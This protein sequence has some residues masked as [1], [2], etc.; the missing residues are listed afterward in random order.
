M[1][2]FHDKIDLNTKYQVGWLYIA[3]V[4]INIIFNASK[5]LYNICFTIIPNIYNNFN[6]KIKE[7]QY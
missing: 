4:S 7:N 6:D 2:F 3:V 5:I 1:I